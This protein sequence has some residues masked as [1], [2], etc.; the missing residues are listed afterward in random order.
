MGFP[1]FS[2]SCFSYRKI[3]RQTFW[4]E[5][6][7]RSC[8]W[9]KTNVEQTSRWIVTHILWW[10][11]VKVYYDAVGETGLEGGPCREW[12]EWKQPS[13]LVYGSCFMMSWCF[14]SLAL[15]TAPARLTLEDILCGPTTQLS[16]QV[17]PAALASQTFLLSLA[18]TTLWGYNFCILYTR[19]K[20]ALLFPYSFLLLIFLSNLL[21]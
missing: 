21:W 10:W 6:E 15:L 17:V 7:M 2:F 19:A 18:L 13:S 3:R 9:S 5:K 8:Q 1:S 11:R 16:L 14:K 12:M 20:L 4:K